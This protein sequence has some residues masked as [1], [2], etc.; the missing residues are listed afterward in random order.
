MGSIVPSTNTTVSNSTGAVN[1][2]NGSVVDTVVVS[3]PARVTASPVA[4][5]QFAVV[6]GSLEFAPDWDT[7][8][9]QVQVDGA[10]EWTELRLALGYDTTTGVLTLTGLAP[11]DHTVRARASVVVAGGG[12]AT[13]ATPV[14]AVWRVEA[15]SGPVVTVVSAPT[16]PLSADTLSVPLVWEAS[17]PCAGYEVWL[18]SHSTDAGPFNVTAP[19]FIVTA[20]VPGSGHTVTVRGVSLG[21]VAGPSATVSWLVL[22][23]LSVSPVVA[24]AVSVFGSEVWLS[25]TGTE[26]VSVSVDGQPMMTPLCGGGASLGPPDT[27]AHVVA[28]YGTIPP[29]CAAITLPNVTTLTYGP[30]GVGPG[31]VSITT[32]PP[33]NTTSTFAAFVFESTWAGAAFQCALDGGAPR[34]CAPHYQMGPLALGPHEVGVWAVDSNDVIM[35]E[36]PVWWA[37]T[38]LPSSFDGMVF[39]G[40]SDGPHSLSIG[41]VDVAD[42]AEPLHVFAWTVA[43]APPCITRTHK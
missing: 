31:T 27:A 5:F 14:V 23:C 21:G 11:G 6:V 43:T 18:S 4:A 36:S 8:T 24:A 10:T 32:G 42:N 22:P 35:S 28:L 38:V 25:W 33:A 7:S 17:E 1:A 30:L 34:P 3:G 20:F 12:L 13:D 19:V 40:L 2:V 37:W 41:A 15:Q 9:I 29:A 26:C 39:Q 16:G